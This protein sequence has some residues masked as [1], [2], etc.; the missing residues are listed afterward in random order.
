[1]KSLSI[2]LF[3]FLAITVFGQNNTS[4]KLAAYMEGQKDIN[5]FSGTVLVMRHDSILLQKAYGWSDYEL[6]VDNTVNTKFTLA[7]ITKHVTAIAIMQLVERGKLS[8]NDKLEKFVPDFP[9]GDLITI[10]MLLTHTSGLTDD[11]MELYLE[12]T[13]M[14]KDSAI[15]YIKKK[16][17]L[18]TPGT[19]LAYSNIGYF[20]LSEIVEKVSGAS[21]DVYLK[22]NIFVVAGMNES[23]LNS[24]EA[25]IK[26]LARSYFR[27]D[28]GMIKNPFINWNINIGLDGMYATA[29][30][31]YKLDRALNG[32]LLLSESSKKQMF[33]QHNKRFSNVGFFNCYG[34]GILINPYF[35][36]GHYM[37]THNGSY[38]GVM[39]TMD[40]YPDDDVFITVLSN[41]ESEANWIGYGLAAIVF[42]K[43]VEIPYK[44]SNFLIDSKLLSKYTGIYGSIE[45]IE[46]HGKLFIKN[47]ETEL[48]PE[49]FN[50]F[51][52]AVNQ[53][54]GYEFVAGKIKSPT[55]IITRGGVKD[56]LIRK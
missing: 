12:Y 16:P 37:L 4:Q 22:K 45:I 43:V 36:H 47:P 31:L 20:L 39:A 49:K 27:G 35:N 48:I 17:I 2:T 52:S 11:Y 3:I 50:K 42:G 6:E 30:D 56:I 38:Y 23:G 14:T 15:N 53:D 46:K 25:V 8:L 26:K 55:L 18:F 21:F 7:S 54:R 51:Y 32:T 40:R 10:H 5:N 41:N 19:K 28:E 33:T 9:N 13:S 34:Y 1:M 24:N 29:G 44:R